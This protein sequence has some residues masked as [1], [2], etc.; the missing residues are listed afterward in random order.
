METAVICK[1]CE[2]PFK[3]RGGLHKHLRGH[4]LDQRSY[5]KQY[6]PRFSRLTKKPLAFRN[7][8]QYLSDEF[9]S[10]EERDIWLSIADKESVREYLLRTLKC[11]I[12][13]K[14]L[15]FAP[16]YA[17]LQANKL[18]DIQFYIDNFGSYSE[19]CST[20]GVECIFNKRAPES[21]HE[22]PDDLEI[23]YDTRETKP[24]KLKQNMREM[25]LDFGDYSL[26]GEHYNYCFIERKAEGDFVS[27]MNEMERFKRELERARQFGAFIYILVESNIEK[28]KYNAIFKKFYRNVSLSF[29]NMRIIQHD[30]HDVCQFV[31]GGTRTECQK[32][33]PMILYHGNE[34]KN[35]DITYYLEKKWLGLLETSN[36]P[37]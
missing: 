25:K 37:L 35:T 36:K 27:T 13:E 31:F 6:E 15:K 4:E 5:Y 2:K 11:R 1:I 3:G 34:L 26:Y 28:I 14:K 22:I 17:E 19:V 24:W 30:Y 8:K 20:L 21:I 10:Q 23:I 29:H 12:E 32:L 18:P 16:C 9:A 7:S 33:A